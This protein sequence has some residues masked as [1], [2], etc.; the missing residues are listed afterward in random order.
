MSAMVNDLLEYA[1]TQLGSGIPVV[2]DEA[3]VQG[4]CDSAIDECAWRILTASLG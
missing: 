2:S 1:R 3:D 4:V